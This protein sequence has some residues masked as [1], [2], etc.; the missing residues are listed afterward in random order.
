M[1]ADSVFPD[2]RSFLDR[3]R[4]DGDLRVVE[5]QVDPH[6]E[7]AEIHR[8]VIAAGGPALL[9]AN[10]KGSDLPVVTNLF[11]TANR[12][13]LAFGS[14]PGDLVRTLVELVQGEFPPSLGRL[15]AKFYQGAVAGTNTEKA[16]FQLAAWEIV[17]E[18]GET[19]GNL[20]SGW[21][22]ATSQDGARNRA[23]TMSSQIGVGTSAGDWNGLYI[24]LVGLHEKPGGDY[25][26]FVV[27]IPSP[28]ASLLGTIGALTLAAFRRRL[29]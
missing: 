21:F 17:F 20:Y 1:S 26:D 22:K 25:Q 15:W 28:T 27:P 24:Q 12:A 4:A 29:G 9:F 19:I 8:R 11:G 18:R 13:R 5:A 23:G 16:A 6:L 14:R 3:L 2:L 7:I 10:P